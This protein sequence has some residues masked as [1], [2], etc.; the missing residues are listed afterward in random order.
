M[1]LEPGDRRADR[2]R[3]V[4]GPASIAAVVRVPPWTCTPA[5]EPPWMDSRPEPSQPDGHAGANRTVPS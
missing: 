2:T 1:D 5:F 3:L 4:A